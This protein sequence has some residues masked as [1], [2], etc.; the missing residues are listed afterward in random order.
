MTTV[1]IEALVRTERREFLKHLCVG[2]A[3]GASVTGIAPEMA[4][5]AEGP[6]VA[7]VVFVLFTRE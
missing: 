7:K 4:T 2:V 5:A 3:A 6:G 1:G